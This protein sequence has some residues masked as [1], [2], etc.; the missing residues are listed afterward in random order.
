MHVCVYVYISVCLYVCL[1]VCMCVYMFMQYVCAHCLRREA[2]VIKVRKTIFERPS[3]GECDLEAAVKDVF[4]SLN[5]HS[6]PLPVPVGTGEG[7]TQIP[8]NER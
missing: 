3:G 1:Y 8:G 7:L 2:G 6:S 5:C 4:L